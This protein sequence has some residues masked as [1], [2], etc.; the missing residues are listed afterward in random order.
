MEFLK[1]HLKSIVLW[2]S[3]TATA[4]LIPSLISNEWSGW[5]TSL[6]GSLI[7]GTCAAV[8]LAI[9]HFY[10]LK[11]LNIDVN[12][13]TKANLRPFQT[14]IINTSHSREEIIKKVEIFFHKKATQVSENMI[15][16]K[17]SNWYG[18]NKT[19][20]EFLLNENQNIQLKII[21]KPVLS[22]TFLDFSEN[23][24]TIKN[25]KKVLT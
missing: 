1:K 2:T 5:Q 7:T 4:Q 21:S 8:I 3:I 19:I 16:I 17:T 22:T 14:T 18:W 10:R 23:L 25:L 11:Y 15:V 24:K 6:F 9:I 12:G 20:V 13:L